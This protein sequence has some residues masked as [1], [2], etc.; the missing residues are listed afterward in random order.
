MF[1]AD[2]CVLRPKM[3][4]N[5]LQAPFAMLQHRKSEENRDRHK[6]LARSLINQPL[7]GFN[8]IRKNTKVQNVQLSPLF[9]HLLIEIDAF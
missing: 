2:L 4:E 6:T 7:E 3:N 9:T 8:T 1:N 5:N